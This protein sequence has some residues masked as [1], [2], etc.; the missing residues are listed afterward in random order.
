MRELRGVLLDMEERKLMYELQLRNRVPQKQ[1]YKRTPILSSSTPINSV[2]QHLPTRNTNEHRNEDAGPLGTVRGLDGK[3]HLTTAERQRR[4][5]AHE[6]LRCGVF[7]H[8]HNV[9]PEND[10]KPQDSE[11]RPNRFTP[12]EKRNEKLFMANI[13]ENNLDDDYVREV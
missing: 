4:I 3:Y 10:K 2:S 11:K 7:G 1:N 12:A 5:L 13:V 6:C 9:C 8:F